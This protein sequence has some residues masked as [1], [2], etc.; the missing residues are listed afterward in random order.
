[1]SY[2]Q[3]RISEFIETE[4]RTEPETK[5]RKGD[6]SYCLKDTEFSFE[7]MKTFWK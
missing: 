7:M 6:G 5:E 4:S 3:S 1:M 2:E